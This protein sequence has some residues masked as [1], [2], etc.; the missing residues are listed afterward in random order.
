M[1]M[2]Y[3]ASPEIGIKE[4]IEQYEFSIVPRSTFAADG[5]MLYCSSKSTLMAIL[6]EGYKKKYRQ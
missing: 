2:V 4:V 5:T 3:K 1:M 6:E